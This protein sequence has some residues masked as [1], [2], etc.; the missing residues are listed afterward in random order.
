MS[1]SN[2][3]MKIKIT[4]LDLSAERYS[5]EHGVERSMGCHLMAVVERIL[6]R[7]PELAG[8]SKKLDKG[9][10]YDGEPTTEA[11]RAAGFTWER[12][13]S[14]E[15]HEYHPD[16]ELVFPGEMLWCEDCDDVLPGGDIGREHCRTTGHKGIWF[17]PDYLIGGQRIVV[18]EWKWTWLSANRCTEDKLPTPAGVWKWPV[19]LMWGCFGF[20]TVYGHIEAMFC[21]GDYKE[22]GY[23][24]E[25]KPIGKHID[26]EFTEK[27][28]ARNRTMIITNARAEGML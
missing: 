20:G 24:G 8:R 3:P 25:P 1:P 22:Y 21:V 28:I 9:K 7:Q 4:P 17:T 6:E 10:Y 11:L 14:A 13:M 5:R 18:G 12:A 19:Q 2:R 15:F 27:E 23:Y 16:E 26:I